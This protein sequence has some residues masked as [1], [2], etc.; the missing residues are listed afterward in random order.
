MTYRVIE[1]L[2][3]GDTQKVN[4]TNF[5]SGLQGSQ[6]KSAQLSTKIVDINIA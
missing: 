2:K 4:T 3:L 6:T 1:V 5:L